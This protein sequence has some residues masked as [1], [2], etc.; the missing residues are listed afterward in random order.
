MSY[1]KDLIFGL[2][3]EK[4]VLPII[5]DFFKREI[6][7]SEGRYTLYDF[8]DNKYIYELKTRNINYGVYPTIMINVKKVIKDKKQIFLFKF[9][10]G[11]YYIKYRESKFNNFEKKLFVRNKRDGI[12]DYLTEC[13]FI[14]LDKLKKII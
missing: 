4:E 8:E 9:N 14:P 13:F 7:K 5:N 3:G 6:T 10:D 12:K 2:N 1:C 11:L